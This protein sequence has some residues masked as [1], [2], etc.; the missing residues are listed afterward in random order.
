MVIGSVLMWVARR[1]AL[2][3]VTAGFP[4]VP[5]RSFG[6]GPGPVG[7]SSSP[8]MS[9]PPP[10]YTAYP[11]GPQAYPAPAPSSS[12][13]YPPPQQYPPA[14]QYPPSTSASPPPPP[15][16]TGPPCASCGRGTTFIAQ[17]GRYYCYPCQRYV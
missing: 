16:T 2:R 10:S 5:V 11:P 1:S 6:S 7:P 14:Q 13:P 8:Q 9:P 12:P 17:Y 3:A 15:G 4:S